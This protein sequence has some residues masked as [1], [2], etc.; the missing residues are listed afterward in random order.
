[1]EKKIVTY[2]LNCKCKWLVCFKHKNHSSIH[3]FNLAYPPVTHPPSSS[4][5][6]AL[7]SIWCLSLFFFF[8]KTASRN[9]VEN[10]S[11]NILDVLVSCDKAKLYCQIVL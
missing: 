5:S 4:A 10:G 6:C 9:A 8:F 11:K 1:M 2:Y 7:K 3:I